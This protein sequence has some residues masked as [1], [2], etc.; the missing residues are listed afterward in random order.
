MPTFRPKK[1]FI[2]SGSNMNFTE[3]VRF[4]TDEVEDLF[5]VGSTG[6]SGNVPANAKTSQIF[7]DTSYSDTLNLGVAQVVLDSDSQILVSGLLPEDVSGSAGDLISLSGENFYRI[8][9]VEFGGQKSNYFDVISEAEITVQVPENADYSKIS[10]VSSER[11]GLN[12]STSQSSGI[13]VNEFVPVPE[14]TGLSSGQMVSGE[15]LT[16]GGVSLSGVIGASIN[17]I[18]MT[19]YLTDSSLDGPNSTGLQFLVPVG[20]VNGSPV[21]SLKSGLSY[22]APSDIAFRPLAKV[23]GV[24]TNVEVGDFIDITGENFHADILYTGENYPVPDATY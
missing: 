18:N 22:S 20:N 5:Y 7:I 8:T 13:T 6:I 24:E 21:L 16:I 1:R 14:V 3:R 4:G 15:I 12:N 11:T 9:D 23:T 2:L 17:S 10:V 19:G